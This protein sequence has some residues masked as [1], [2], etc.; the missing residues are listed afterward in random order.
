MRSGHQVVY[1]GRVGTIARWA[2]IIDPPKVIVRFVKGDVPQEWVY[3]ELGE[4]VEVALWP[5]FI[6]RIPSVLAIRDMYA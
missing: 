2:N 6:Q 3:R 5:E 4:Y 1:K